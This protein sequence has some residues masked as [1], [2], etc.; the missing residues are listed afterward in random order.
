MRTIEK[1]RG[2]EGDYRSLR[3]NATPASEVEAMH[4]ARIGEEDANKL[5]ALYDGVVALRRERLTQGIAPENW[6]KAERRVFAAGDVVAGKPPTPEA[7]TDLDRAEEKLREGLA[8]HAEDAEALKVELERLRAITAGKPKIE[9]SVDAVKG[10]RGIVN[11]IAE[12]GIATEDGEAA[13]IAEGSY[14]IVAEGDKWI[15]TGPGFV[16]LQESEAGCG[17]TPVRALTALLSGTTA[18]DDGR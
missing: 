6:T 2:I 13:A 18:E 7:K 1:V 15:A 8:L 3:E 5:L 17:T 9:V 10:M 11:A 4:V 14:N 12:A 16:N